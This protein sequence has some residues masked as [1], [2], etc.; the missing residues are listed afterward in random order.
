VSAILKGD[1][2]TSELR[3]FRTI[4]LRPG[5]SRKTRTHCYDSYLLLCY[6]NTLTHAGWAV[7]PYFRN[8][9]CPIDRATRKFD[10]ASGGTKTWKDHI[11]S[12]ESGGAAEILKK[13]RGREAVES[14]IVPRKLGAMAK[15]A[16]AM[17]AARAVFLDMR[18][19]SF[20][21]PS[22]GISE[23]AACLFEEGQRMPAAGRP[24]MT[25][26]L[27]SAAAVRTSLMDMTTVK[28]K[29][30]REIS[31]PAAMAV[32]G[33]MSSDGLKRSAQVSSTTT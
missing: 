1:P 23:F 13:K 29:Y 8:G 31:I 10:P 22:R 15:K 16:L 11:E 27:P 6:K 26:Y 9:S 5:V 12:H 30:D 28:L 17:A 25:D 33:G 7:C 4:M 20:A 3:D 14:T 2:T 32:G 19:I 21:E 24:D 18:P